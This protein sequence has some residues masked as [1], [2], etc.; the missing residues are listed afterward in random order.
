MARRGVD[1][2]QRRRPAVAVVADRA[3][4]DLGR[5]LRN[6]RDRPQR[7]HGLPPRDSP[8]QLDRA[9]AD[10]REPGPGAQPVGRGRLRP[11]RLR[12]A[13]PGDRGALV[14]RCC[15]GRGWWRRQLW[16][17]LRPG[18]PQPAAGGA[19]R[20]ARLRSH[21]RRW[22][23]EPRRARRGGEPRPHPGGAAAGAQD[24]SLAVRLQLL[25]RPRACSPVGRGAMD[26]GA[27]RT[28]ATGA[29]RRR[30]EVDPAQWPAV[31]VVGLPQLA[32]RRGRRR[33]RGAGG[34]GGCRGGADTSGL[35]RAKTIVRP[36]WQR[37]GRGDGQRVVLYGAYAA[38]RW[39]KVDRLGVKV[40]V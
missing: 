18:G 26:D 5:Q 34:R 12:L 27:A 35:E 31:G 1:C 36:H 29:P 37:V 21:R 14:L 11:R 2:D 17:A 38:H 4:D 10:R 30:E 33:R 40:G 28:R 23:R 19:G 25:R 16:A 13:A 20:A 15:A 32:L 6:R 8:R 7:R 39:R 22:D 9:G 24:P 3:Q